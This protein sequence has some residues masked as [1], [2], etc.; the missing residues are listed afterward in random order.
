[1]TSPPKGR[2]PFYPGQPVPAELFVGRKA[3]IDR[4]TRAASQVG[5]GKQQAI[6]VTGEY[7]IGK[8]SLAGYIRV[9][10][11]REYSLFGIHVFLGGAT[12]LEEVAIKTVEAIIQSGAFNATWVEAARNTLSKYVGE[13]SLFGVT[14]RL[15]QLRAD[16]P[17]LSRGYLP[18]LR[19]L[20]ERA[21]E[22]GANGILL[23]LD[24]INGISSNPQFAHFIKA[25]VD[26]NAL[27]RPP[28]PLLL[29]LCGVEG[30]RREMIQHH[31]PI[32]RIFDIAEIRPMNEAEMRDFFQHSFQ[33]QDIQVES[34]AMPVLM[35]FGAGYPKV[36]HIVGDAAFWIDK[37][38]KIDG[39][40]AV[41]AVVAAAE[42]VGRKFVD[43]QVMKALKSK[44]YQSILKKL[45]KADFD[46]AFQKAEMAKGLTEG[47]RRKFNN[48]LQK[49]KKL[50]VLRAGGELGEYVFNS[51]LVRLY[52]RLNSAETP[53]K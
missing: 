17:D 22:G 5:A 51:R 19:G 37:D 10:A 41:R 39:E 16:G 28:L 24:E 29:M 15:D 21:K 33:S 23:V 12:T 48:F 20:F 40:D 34:A 8:S 47:E 7:G 35:H 14:L 50:D 9:L 25:L 42:D 2:S 32:E 38:G 18:L 1:M 6:F 45:A 44:D 53:S 52:I 30:R 4:I 46:L 13:Q 27:S 49:M 11:E 3:E 31:Q 26:E 43:Q 36:M